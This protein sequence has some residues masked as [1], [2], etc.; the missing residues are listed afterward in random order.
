MKKYFSLL[1]LFVVFNFQSYSEAPQFSVEFLE[2]IKNKSPEL[3]NLTQNLL[4][5]SKKSQESL[6][7]V[8]DVGVF[9]SNNTDIYD[10]YVYTYNGNNQVLNEEVRSWEGDAWEYISR[11]S[12][13]YDSESNLIKYFNV[14]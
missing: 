9:Q 2:I 12:N 11:I 10:S 7:L 4:D 5:R 8:N 6:Y 3:Y 13:S 1:V 14:K